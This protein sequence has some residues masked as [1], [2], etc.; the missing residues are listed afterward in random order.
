MTSIES[1]DE[2]ATRK[3]HPQDDERGWASPEARAAARDDLLRRAAQVMDPD[4]AADLRQQASDIHN[5]K[6]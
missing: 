5:E 2:H 1:T 6:A 4:E 3:E